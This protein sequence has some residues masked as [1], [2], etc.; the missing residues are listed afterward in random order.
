M[1]SRG[2]SGKGLDHPAARLPSP[3][4][5][6]PGEPG[7]SP[8]ALAVVGQRLA[9]VLLLPDEIKNVGGIAVDALAREP[10]GRVPAGVP[11]RPR[12][13]RRAGIRHRRWFVHWSPPKVEHVEVPIS[14]RRPGF[15]GQGSLT[16][17]WTGSSA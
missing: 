9:Q 16:L 14:G 6:V 3:A 2:G 17:S 5:G 11:R 15:S 12:R 7:D 10:E 8:P 1:A 4:A 13:G